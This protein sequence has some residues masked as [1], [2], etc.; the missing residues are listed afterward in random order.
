MESSLKLEPHLSLNFFFPSGYGPG[1]GKNLIYFQSRSQLVIG[2][3]SGR[4]ASCR[5]QLSAV[6]ASELIFV[7]S[8]SSLPSSVSA[9]SA[10]T[11]MCKIDLPVFVFSR[12]S[13]GWCFVH[14]MKFVCCILST[15]GLGNLHTA[16]VETGEQEKGPRSTSGWKVVFAVTCLHLFVLIFQSLLQSINTCVSI[17][18]CLSIGMM[19]TKTQ[20]WHLKGEITSCTVKDTTLVKSYCMVCFL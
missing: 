20:R 19:Q 3:K 2:I 13:L 11:K 9:C 14:D 8:S 7:V 5:V 12:L 18:I 4:T 1:Q 16:T 10:V 6:P 15:G 17:N